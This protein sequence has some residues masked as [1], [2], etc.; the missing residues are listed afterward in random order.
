MIGPVVSGSDMSKNREPIGDKIQ[1]LLLGGNL[2]KSS[3]VEASG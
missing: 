3:Q 1:I 2:I